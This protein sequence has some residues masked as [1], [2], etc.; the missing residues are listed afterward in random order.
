MCNPVILLQIVMMSPGTHLVKNHESQS[1]LLNMVDSF[2]LH[3][4]PKISFEKTE[5]LFLG[6]DQKSTTE[7]VISLARNR[8]ITA[9]KAIKILGVH[10]T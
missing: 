10:F 8:K 6:N 7:T 4:G 5:V 1:T 3:S 2:S 9:K